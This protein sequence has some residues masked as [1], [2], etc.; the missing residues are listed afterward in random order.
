MAHSVVHPV[1][2]EEVSRAVFTKP[3]PSGGYAS[4]HFTVPVFF[5]VQ[6]LDLLTPPIHTHIVKG[7]A[8]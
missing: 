5:F 8:L 6:S 1:E 7:Q 2:W 3:N 4:W